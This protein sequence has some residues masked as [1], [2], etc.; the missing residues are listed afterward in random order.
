MKELDRT[1]QP[2]IHP[3]TRLE[4]LQPKREVL[5][6]GAR[7]ALLDKTVQEDIF[8]I[9]IL[10]HGGQWRQSMPLQSLFTNKMLGEGTRNLTSAQISERL[11][12]LGAWLEYGAG[13]TT[14]S[15]YLFSLNKYAKETLEVLNQ[16]LK[17]P[18][19]PSQEFQVMVNTAHQ[20]FLVN[21]NRVEAKARMAFGKLLYG[22]N[23][24]Y[25]KYACSED[26]SRISTS[27]LQDFYNLYY[28]CQNSSI[29]LSGNPDKKTVQLV[30]SLFGDK[31][32]GHDSTLVPIIPCMPETSNEKRIF[33][34]V[35]DSL[36]S[37]V[38]MG[39]LS[40][41][42][43]HPDFTKL[44]VAMTLLGGYFGSRLMSNL[45]ED[46]GYTYGIDADIIPAPYETTLIVSTQCDAKYVEPLIEEVYREIDRLCQEKVSKEELEM[47]KSYMLGEQVRR[48]EG[49]SLA[50]AFTYAEVSG[51]PDD[52]M[53]KKVDA[54][55]AVTVQD[56][57]E[58][59]NTYLNH[60][61]MKEVV[62]G[63]KI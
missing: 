14:N 24:P 31:P 15:I 39:C 35:P 12:S 55:R 51:F 36:Q 43:S 41:R 57:W 9:D 5:L 19:F 16:I 59:A 27:N 23:H 20:R 48:F 2:A 32:W 30:Q 11:D 58:M 56:I 60:D 1:K 52:F 3:L 63:K 49:L 62:V 42:Q 22:E 34:E 21:S 26:Y 25:G 47:V 6:N 18:V 17:E 50:D 53:Q 44:S 13:V 29:Y 8:R 40:I 10:I 7:F 61:A 45:R 4:L 37:A 33:V 28:H 38:R 54:I 46:K